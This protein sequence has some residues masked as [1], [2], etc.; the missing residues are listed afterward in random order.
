MYI[1]RNINLGGKYYPRTDTECADKKVC[2]DS[3]KIVIF[4]REC[5][6]LSPLFCTG[7]MLL[8]VV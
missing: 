8:Y 3:V 2:A 4:G 1:E 6:V 5:A 7:R